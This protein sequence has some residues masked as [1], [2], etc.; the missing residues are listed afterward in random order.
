MQHR[1]NYSKIVADIANAKKV[2]AFS[3]KGSLFVEFASMPITTQSKLGV[4]A[5]IATASATPKGKSLSISLNV[6][7]SL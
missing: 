1:R 2:L 6:A 4:D 5:S 3:Y 7:T